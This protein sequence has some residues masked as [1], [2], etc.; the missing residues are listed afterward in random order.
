M[1][2]LG[3]VH[4]DLKPSN[5]LIGSS[6]SLSRRTLRASLTLLRSHLPPRSREPHQ[7][8][9]LWTGCYRLCPFQRD[10]DDREHSSEAARRRG[11]PHV[12]FV[13][14][15]PPLPS[16]FSARLRAYWMSLSG[17]GTSLYIAPEVEM[18]G[19]IRGNAYDGKADLY[20]LGFVF[21]LPPLICLP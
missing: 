11:G 10:S 5:L 7:D 20:S 1:T 13:Y 14:P 9:R 17:I 2:E 18:S 21:F 19:K 4:R 3:I 6:L 16:S 8:R 12:R 15:C